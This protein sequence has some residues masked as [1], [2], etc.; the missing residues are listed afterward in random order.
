MP[1]LKIKIVR[2]V[3]PNKRQT[4]FRLLFSPLDLPEYVLRAVTLAGLDDLS[5]GRNAMNEGFESNYYSTGYIP[6]IKL[7]RER[8]KLGLKEA[9]DYVDACKTAVL[10]GKL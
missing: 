8:T 9:K 7:V 6:T 2:L 1:K 4:T 3:R 5:I 10:E